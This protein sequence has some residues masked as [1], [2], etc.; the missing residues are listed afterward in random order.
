[1]KTKGGRRTGWMEW[2]RRRNWEWRHG[3]AGKVG[4]ESGRHGGIDE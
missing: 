2:I 1:M 4:N 3:E